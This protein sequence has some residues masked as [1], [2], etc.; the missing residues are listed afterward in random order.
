MSGAANKTRISMFLTTGQL[1][2]LKQVSE[3]TGYN[4]S[5]IVR[6]AVDGYLDAMERKAKKKQ[7]DEEKRSPQ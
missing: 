2:K 3:D 5:E 1:E 4:V 7:V 6:R